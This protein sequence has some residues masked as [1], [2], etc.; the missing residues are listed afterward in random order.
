MAETEQLIVSK[1]RVADRGEVYTAKRE[2]NAMLDLVK[3]ETERIESKFLE[4][5]CGTGNFLVEILERKL[6]VVIKRYKKSQIDFERY[7]VLT[8]SSIYGIDIILGNVEG[9][10]GRLFELFYTHYSELFK[11]RI[12]ESCLSTIKFLLEKNIVHGNA[13]TLET[14]G[15]SPQPIVFSDWSLVTGSMMKRRDFAFHELSPKEK[16]QKGDLFAE[17]ELSDDIGGTGFIPEPIKE[18]PLTHF[19]KISNAD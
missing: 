3:Q 8:V 7:G 15:A 6:H 18:Y 1:Q 14:E 11:S 5:A 12:K 19:L 9:A 2:V 17:P 4:P 13:L 10:R 16:I